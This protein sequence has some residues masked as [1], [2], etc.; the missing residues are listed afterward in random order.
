MK[1]FFYISLLA[2]FACAPDTED[3]MLEQQLT[4]SD[5]PESINLEMNLETDN[6]LT[7]Q[8]FED[9]ALIDPNYSSEW[10]QA[11][12]YDDSFQVEE[13]IKRA[14]NFSGRFEINSSDP[15]QSGG[16]RAEM[17]QR[18]DL[19][20]Q[21]RWYG[22]SQYF[23]ASY[24]FDSTPELA[25]QW[26]DQ[27]DEGE[28]ASRTPSNFIMIRNNRFIWYL[29]WDADA[30]TYNNSPDRFMEIDLGPVPK[31]QWI[32]WVVHI[33]FAYDNTGI[34]EVWKNGEKVIDRH[35][36]PN[37]YNDTKLPYFKL[38][39]YK[40]DWNGSSVNQKVMY[41]DEVRI[42]NEYSNYDE[43]KPK[44]LESKIN[45]MVNSYTVGCFGEME[46]TCLLIQEGNMIGS[47]NWENFYFSNSIEGF[48][49]EPGFVYGLVV[50]KTEVENPPLDGSSIKYEL[51]EIVSKEAQ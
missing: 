34:L 38:G 24:V 44:G 3:A 8:Y 28:S 29:S 18:L 17:T 31:D 20:G 50:K 30:I 10:W 1:K 16:I 46:G 48:S 40:W 9:P 19:L 33:K 13:T 6:L 42:G 43:V 7:V 49:Y 41:W 36:Q 51:V 37:S 15:K 23:P 25:G 12:A 22:F 2:I 45:M 47:E 4:S 27:P 35:N 21:E 11:F 26:H 32:D 5:T 14:G 39:I